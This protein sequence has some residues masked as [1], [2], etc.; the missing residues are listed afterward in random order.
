MA[1]YKTSLSRVMATHEA[2]RVEVPKPHTFNGK[3]DAMEIAE[4]L[5]DYKESMSSNDE[6]SRVSHNSGRGEE[7]SPRGSKDD[8]STEGGKRCSVVLPGMG[9]A[10]C[11][12]L[13]KIKASASNGSLRQS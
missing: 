6:G 13:G 7:V 10:R 12:T 2:P 9:R 8:C 3:Q 4:S 5:M 1:I 11:S